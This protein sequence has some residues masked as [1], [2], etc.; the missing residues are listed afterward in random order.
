MTDSERVIKRL[1]AQIKNAHKENNDFAYIPVGTAKLIVE[2]LEI[3]KREKAEMEGGGSSWWDVC[4][5]CHTSI[6]KT[7]KY[8]PQCGREIDWG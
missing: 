7:Y 8:C 6:N 1:N 4:G 2:L 5:E 3:N